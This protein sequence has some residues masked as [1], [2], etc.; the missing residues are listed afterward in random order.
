MG[1]VQNLSFSS[2]LS[3]LRL[4]SANDD[5]INECVAVGGMRICRGRQSARRRP[6]PVPLCP[7]QISHDLTWDETHAP[8][9]G[10]QREL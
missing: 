6:T 7:P 9:K 3:V 4:Y 5:I 1:A 8:M 2:M 10:S